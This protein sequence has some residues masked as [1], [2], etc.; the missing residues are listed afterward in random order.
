MFATPRHM[1]SAVAGGN[2][3]I[4]FARHGARDFRTTLSVIWRGKATILWTT[5]LSLLLAV[6]FMLGVPRQYTA[7]TQIL[8]DPT[9]LRVAG[10]EP[11]QADQASDAAVLQVDSQVRALSSD[12]V[13]RRVV[14]AE[15]LDR[16][17][18]FA[19]HASW[20]GGGV[21]DSSLA[22]LNAL[23][24]S[25]QV[26]RAQHSYVVDVS[27]INRDPVKAARIANAIAQAYL[28]E[29]TDVRADAARQT[30][31]AWSARLNELKETLA[32]ALEKLKGN[33]IT[34]DEAMV[35]LR[36]LER[37][38]QA[39]RASL[40]HARETS[41]Q[42]HP[43]TKNIRVISAADPPLH[44]S[45]PPSNVLI[46]LGA[47]CLGAAAGAGILIMRESY[48]QGR[49][50]GGQSRT[51]RATPA[52]AARKFRPPA[53]VA[54][55]IPVLAVLPN[56]DVSFGLEA[57]KNPTSRFAKEIQKVHKAVA[58]SHR[59][60]GNASILVVASDDEDETVMVALAL[61]AVA[62]TTQRVLL[63]DADLERRT[64]SAID[65]DR[66]EAGLIDV[67]CERRELAEV[68]VCD[69]ETS[70]DLM[71]FVS[72]GSRRNREIGEADIKRAFEQTTRFDT[73]IVAAVDLSC[74]PST[75]LFAGLVD[76][77]VLVARTDKPKADAIE[78]FISRLGS[79]AR[80]IRGA[81]LTGV[82]T[83]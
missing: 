6:A 46:A 45:F 64:L 68:I 71:P 82:G 49:S 1:Q 72:T 48:D 79:D 16:D 26:K 5:A 36:E 66:T 23:K 52:R 54:A 83:A 39:S 35:T 57:A 20:F 8:I 25:V 33:A 69:R 12:H 73:V 24:R 41:E 18:E 59:T 80:K 47:L 53:A 32:A 61:A 60:G 70:V 17:P 3:P 78:R 50:R 14:A 67:A 22:A 43:D 10:N 2:M 21:G 34:P 30:S 31:Q 29:Q 40:V 44:R 27:V 19:G 76:H 74:D 42:E 51:V 75:S 4:G 65:A 81:V 28:A 77:I 15:A 7:V 58:A 62:A 13:L 55:S 9:D 56:V 38:V 63:I 37:G 11:T